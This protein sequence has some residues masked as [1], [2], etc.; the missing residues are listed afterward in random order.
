[1]TT[2]EYKTWFDGLPDDSPKKLRELYARELYAGDRQRVDR[3]KKWDELEDVSREHWRG[4]AS[5]MLMI[6]A[7]YARRVGAAALL[8]VLGDALYDWGDKATS[9]KLH[10]NARTL[11]G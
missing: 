11:E 2:D 9:T 4:E 3:T 5:R 8:R 7:L 1:M 10:D 6:T